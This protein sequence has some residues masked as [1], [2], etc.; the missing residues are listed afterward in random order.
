MSKDALPDLAQQ[1]HSVAIHLLRRLRR[2]DDR[3]GLSGPRASALSV[4][5]FGGPASLAQLAKAE[6]VKPPTMAR[7]VDALEAAG[8]ARRETDKSDLRAVRIRATPKG[9]K[10]LLEGRARRLRQLT[11]LLEA[12]TAPERAAMTTA[13]STLRRLLKQSD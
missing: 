11:Q 5:V 3:M 1:L 10:L 8:L 12:A 13:V 7:L 9:R 6:Q 2:T 4:L